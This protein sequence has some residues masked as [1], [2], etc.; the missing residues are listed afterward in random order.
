VSKKE[1]NETTQVGNDDDPIAV[2]RA[3]QAK[4]GKGAF[5]GA[6]NGLVEEENF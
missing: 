2:L 1:D 5:D 3:I 4:L 6:L